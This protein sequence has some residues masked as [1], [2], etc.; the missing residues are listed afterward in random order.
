MII[1]KNFFR[2]S[3]LYPLSL[4]ITYA[5]QFHPVE[6][7]ATRSMPYLSKDFRMWKQFLFPRKVVSSQL[8]NLIPPPRKMTSNLVKVMYRHLSGA[9]SS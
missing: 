8:L 3:C 1:D 2:L 9:V 6:R 4:A 7:I 5:F